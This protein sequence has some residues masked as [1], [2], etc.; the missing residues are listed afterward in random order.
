M[1]AD[2]LVLLLLHVVVRHLLLLL[3]CH[4]VLGLHTAAAMHARLLCGN[5]SMAYVFGRVNCGFGVDAIL[6]AGRGF[7]RIQAC[8][9]SC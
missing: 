6:V 4:A 8:L 7:G 3:G 1:S 9:G 5:L 2:L